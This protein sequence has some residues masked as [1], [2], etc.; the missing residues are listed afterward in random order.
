MSAYA[1]RK[2]KYKYCKRQR[3]Y[4]NMKSSMKQYITKY[5][6]KMPGLIWPEISI[7]LIFFFLFSDSFPFFTTLSSQLFHLQ[8]PWFTN[9]SKF[10]S[11]LSLIPV[12]SC[13]FQDLVFF[14][15][16]SPSSKF[17][18]FKFSLSCHRLLIP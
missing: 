2:T 8:C 13:L 16:L 12:V 14:S 1:K 18:S 6:S 11:F 17:L 15:R 10:P 9:F 7:L 4:P 3:M 5:C